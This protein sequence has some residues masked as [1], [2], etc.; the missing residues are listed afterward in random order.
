MIAPCLMRSYF[1]WA[2]ALAPWAASSVALLKAARAGLLDW[3][4]ELRWLPLIGLGYA[5]GWL[6]ALVLDALPRLH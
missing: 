5:L 3:R 2:L 6:A 4:E 1:L